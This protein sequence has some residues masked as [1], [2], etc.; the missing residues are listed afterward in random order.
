MNPSCQRTFLRFIGASPWVASIGGIRAYA[1]Q[2]PEVAEAI[3]DPKEALSVFDFE[4]AAHRKMLPGH[5][6]YMMSGVDD[7]L[8]RDV[9]HEGYRQVQLRPRRLRDATKIDTRDRL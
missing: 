6:A 8:T 4:T 2:A 9:N 7:D 5:W 1:E 3:S